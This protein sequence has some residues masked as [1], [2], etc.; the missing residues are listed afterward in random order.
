M[1]EKLLPELRD[2]PGNVGY[3]NM[4]DA[5]VA[6]ALNAK[7]RTKQI[8]AVTAEGMEIE[9]RKARTVSISRADEVGLRHVDVG[10]VFS[11]RVQVKAA[12]KGVER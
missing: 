9:A 4:T 10:N 1:Y 11:A 2:D 7:T 8:P 5:E 3:A 6:D 12:K